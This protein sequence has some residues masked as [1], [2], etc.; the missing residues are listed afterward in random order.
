MPDRE[1]RNFIGVLVPHWVT[2]LPLSLGAWRL[3]FAI[4]DR[5]DG[6]PIEDV[7]ANKP[8]SVLL[9]HG[10]VEVRGD[11]LIAPWTRPAEVGE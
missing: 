10:A 9:A 1:S 7:P 4:A 3:Y 5:C 8:L 11:V 2:R 6:M